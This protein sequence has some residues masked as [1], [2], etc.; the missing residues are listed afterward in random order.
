MPLAGRHQSIFDYAATH[1]VT[2][3]GQRP[4]G[5]ATNPLER[6]RQRHRPT[7]G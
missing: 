2:A 3:N 7:D 6:R 4:V 5:D 1:P